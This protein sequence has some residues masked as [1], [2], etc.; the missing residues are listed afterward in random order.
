MII[1][2][3]QTSSTNKITMSFY[4]VAGLYFLSFVY[5]SFAVTLKIILFL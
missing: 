1:K 5:G 3:N 4:N 2:N